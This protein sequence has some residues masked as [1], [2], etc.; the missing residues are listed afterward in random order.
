MNTRGHP[1]HKATSR[2]SAATQAG[3]RFANFPLRVKPHQ[4]IHY[5]AALEFLAATFRRKK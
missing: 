5:A 3:N 2:G 1:I 4:K